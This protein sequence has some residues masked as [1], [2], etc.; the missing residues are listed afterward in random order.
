[1][2]ALSAVWPPSV[3]KQRVGAL[4]LDDAFDDLGRDRLDVGGVGKLGVRH[5]RGGVRVQQH[6]AQAL[7]LEHAARLSS[8]VVELAG[9]ADDDRAGADHHD[10]LDIVAAR[11]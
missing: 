3:G 10:R 8:R 4:L 6:D 5:D 7:G 11:H 9:L 1:M 2:A